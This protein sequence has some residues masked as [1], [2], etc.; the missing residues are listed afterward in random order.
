[1]CPI[2]SQIKGYPFEVPIPTGLPVT[3]AVLS[4]QVKNV[5][6]SARRAKFACRFPKTVTD[7][8][9]KKLGNLVSP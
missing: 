8:A 2:A 6:W 4:D 7:E 5:D 1:M 9:L 3:G